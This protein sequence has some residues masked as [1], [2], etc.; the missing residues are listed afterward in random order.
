MTLE[1]SAVLNETHNN[2]TPP[3][4]HEVDYSLSRI[5]SLKKTANL[6]GIQISI[7]ILAKQQEQYIV[8]RKTPDGNNLIKETKVVAIGQTRVRLK[9]FGNHRLLFFAM[10]ILDKYTDKSG[11]FNEDLFWQEINNW[12]LK[13]RNNKYRQ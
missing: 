8:E 9:V 3:Y 11:N 1:I 5:E 13:D 12:V 10:D 2:Q 4:T 6:L 7:E